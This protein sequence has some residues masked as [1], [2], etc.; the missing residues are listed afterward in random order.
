MT[1]STALRPQKSAGRW[2]C[3]WHERVHRRLE[4]RGDD[5]VIARLGA[6]GEEV[7]GRGADAVCH[8]VAKRVDPRGLGGVGVEVD[9]VDVLGAVASEL[10]RLQSSCRSRRPGSARRARPPRG[11]GGARS[12]TRPC[13]GA[14]TSPWVTR[15]GKASGYRERPAASTHG[16][17]GAAW[18]PPSS[19]GP[20]SPGRG[21]PRGLPASAARAAPIC[22]GPTPQQPPISCAP[23]SRQR[24]AMRANSS[25]PASPSTC[26]P[27]LVR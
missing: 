13:D 25:G 18:A 11:T 8:A 27:S 3:A 20:P 2:V 9:G 14:N 5:D 6:P 12:G 23:S 26:Q 15:S 22:S 21:A 16:S 17:G 4:E 10:D 24:T 19:W 7:D 1:W